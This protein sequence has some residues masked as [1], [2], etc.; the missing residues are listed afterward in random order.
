MADSLTRAF[1]FAVG[2]VRTARGLSQDD[3]ASAAEID[4]T[5]VSQIER[6]I[7]SPTLRVLDQ[8]AGA[9]G[10]RP[11]QLV[12]RAEQIRDEESRAGN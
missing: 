2:E 4:R 5:Y 8:L 12:I 11:S 7:K 10:L 9:L 6:A 1:G 3:L